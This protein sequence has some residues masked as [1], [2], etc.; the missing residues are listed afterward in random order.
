LIYISLIMNEL[1][2]YVSVAYELKKSQFITLKDYVLSFLEYSEQ[3]AYHFKSA[4]ICCINL[5]PF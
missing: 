3:K 1:W 2:N 4:S 5:K